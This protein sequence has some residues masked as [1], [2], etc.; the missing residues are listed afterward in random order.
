MTNG[1]VLIPL[2]ALWTCTAIL[3]YVGAS[4][5]RSAGHAPYTL[6]AAG[7][8]LLRFLWLIAP[9]AFLVW[10]IVFLPGGADWLSAP[11]S[12][13]ESIVMVAFAALAGGMI[14]Y[15]IA[16]LPRRQR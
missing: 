1:M 6:F 4:T 3:M 5:A 14:T 7:A 2:A 12:A 9:P 13:D 10:S 15:R 16:G 11:A 8:S